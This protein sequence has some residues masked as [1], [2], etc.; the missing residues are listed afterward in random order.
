MKKLFLSIGLAL[1]CLAGYSQE[2][3]HLEF[4]GIPVTG[5]VDNMVLQLK[6]KGYKQI[7]ESS[8]LTGKVMGQKAKIT[9]AST[10]D[11]SKVYLVLVEC[12]TKKSWE[13]VKTCYDSMRMQL[14]ARYG[15]P[16]L[17]K[18][19]YDSPLAEADPLQALQYGNC[20]FISHY[21]APGGEIILTITKDAV[22]QLYF[23][24]TSN[25]VSLY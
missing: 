11:G 3:P 12:V 13:Q 16:I 20:T 25:A 17:Y 21:Q 24:D 14:V 7:K 5:S 18:E 9:V 10:P 6:S 1:M 22:V 8:S 23:V 19:E 4:E 2:K 15:D